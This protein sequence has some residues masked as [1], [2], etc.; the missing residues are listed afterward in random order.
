MAD[1]YTSIKTGFPNSLPSL[2]SLHSSSTSSPPGITV[3]PGSATKCIVSPRTS[4][5]KVTKNSPT[6]HVSPTRAST[7]FHNA[8]LEMAT[9]KIEELR[10]SKLKFLAIISDLQDENIK[11]KDSANSALDD[12]DKEIKIL[13]SNAWLD[14]L[15]L[16]QRDDEIAALRRCLDVQS[17]DDIDDKTKS[18]REEAQR[19]NLA[20]INLGRVKKELMEEIH[21]LEYQKEKLEFS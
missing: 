17:E 4:R 21:A 8:K 3:T 6:G 20:I 2:T 13:M 16:Q 19:L 1:C 7:L 9:V 15:A 18:L 14:E 11:V 10:Q 5:S 12:K